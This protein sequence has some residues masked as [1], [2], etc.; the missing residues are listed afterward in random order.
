MLL[1]CRP[2]PRWVTHPRIE[3][4]KMLAQLKIQPT[5]VMFHHLIAAL[6]TVRGFHWLSVV[7]I[8]IGPFCLFKSFRL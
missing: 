3:L 5:A 6:P 8:D 4:P 2:P 7:R 1:P